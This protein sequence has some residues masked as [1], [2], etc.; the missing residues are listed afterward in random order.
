M[1]I[2]VLAD[3]AVKEYST[4]ILVTKTIVENMHPGGT[5]DTSASQ[6][7][8]K[9]ILKER[10]SDY[11]SRHLEIIEKLDDVGKQIVKQC[12]EPGSSSWLSCLPL[13]GFDFSFNK[14]EFRDLIRLR[15]GMQLS[16]IKTPIF[17][18]MWNQV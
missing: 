15:Y 2:P 9:K 6:E 10:V 14:S 3:M 17:L 11:E 13:K 12:I 4:S 8:L 18:C 7:E 1:G 5:T 16:M